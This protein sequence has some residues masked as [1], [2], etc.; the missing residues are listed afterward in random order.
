MTSAYANS[1]QNLPK[2]ESFDSYVRKFRVICV[3]HGIPIG[4]ASN[5]PVFL[6]KLIIDRPLAMDF[7]GFVSKLSD[8]EGGELT[9]DQLLAV[10][11]EGVAKGEVPPDD[12][13]LKRTVNDLRAMLAGVDI[14]DP[15]QLE[16]EPFSR[17]EVPALQSE[18]AWQSNHPHSADPVPSPTHSAN[19]PAPA[20]VIPPQLDEA[21]HRLELTN[22]E[23]K[24]HLEAIDKRMSQLEPHSEGFPA[25]GNEGNKRI[26]RTAEDVVVPS[27]EQLIHKPTSQSRL[28]LESAPRAQDLHFTRKS[29][30][31]PSRVPLETYSESSGY[32]RAVSAL[33]LILILGAAAYAGYRYRVPLQQQASALIQKV[34]SRNTSTPPPTQSAPQNAATGDET[35]A[36]EPQQTQPA[37]QPQQ[38][39]T[40]PAHP[41]NAQATQSTPTG[42]RTP[43]RTSD[44]TVARKSIADRVAGQ[45]TPTQPDGISSS[46]LAGAVRVAPAVMETKLVDSRVPAYPDS[47]KI[48]GVEGSVIMQAIIS[49]DGTVKRVHVIQ[50]DSR[51]RTSAVEAVYKWRYR[52]YMLN[53]QPV[54][55]ATTI[56]VDFDLDR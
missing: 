44:S 12:P 31:F 53:G 1:I 55:V 23:L 45:A 26:N 11:V 29:G 2:P 17:D 20:Q 13:G 37:V 5:L 41:A 7:W 21:L 6:Q 49:K 36:T 34:Q 3:M 35:S 56:T 9:D 19:P 42:S 18:K 8:R 15:G 30:D 33:V 28:V 54:D 48:Q 39:P 16:P 51:L 10:V 32:G 22:L 46:D 27:P 47:A 25:G 24:H 4:S 52:P 40:P 38:A 50:G 14:H 43:A